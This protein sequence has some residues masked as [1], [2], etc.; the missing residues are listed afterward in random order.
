M[1]DAKRPFINEKW[2]GS[3]SEIESA[4]GPPQ[5][6]QIFT[7]WLKDAILSRTGMNSWPT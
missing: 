2:S 5:T 6:S 1:D 4:K 7:D 3:K